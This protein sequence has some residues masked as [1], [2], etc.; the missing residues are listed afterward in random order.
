VSPDRRNPKGSSKGN[1]SHLANDIAKVLVLNRTED[2]DLK[3]I[4][5]RLAAEQAMG[6]FNLLL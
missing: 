1:A 5:E 6:I 3:P 4:L 2:I